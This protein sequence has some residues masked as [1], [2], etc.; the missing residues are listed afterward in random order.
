[1]DRATYE[2]NWVKNNRDKVRANAKRYYEKNKAKIKERQ[3]ERERERY[4]TDPVY[5]AKILAKNN[6]NREQTYRDWY[7]KRTYGIDS[8]HYE[9]MLAQQS[10]TCAICKGGPRGRHKRFHVD[11]D[12]VT[13][14]V[15]GLLCGPCNQ[16]IGPLNDDQDRLKAAIA[17]LSAARAPSEE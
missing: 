16:A 11:H 4:K 14:V 15:R 9:A 17:Y 1:M 7:L 10:G 13:G 8:V 5:R 6:R 2:K 12:H 3:K